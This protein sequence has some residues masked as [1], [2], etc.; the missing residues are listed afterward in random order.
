MADLQVD[1]ERQHG[2]LLEDLV[3]NNDYTLQGTSIKAQAYLD[4]LSRRQKAK[5]IAV[6]TDDGRVKSKLRELG[7]P[8]TLFG[9]D[10]ADRR[11][12][13]RHVL[14]RLQEADNEDVEMMSDNG[15]NSE[16][17]ADEDEEFY[18]PGD[19]DLLAS[20]RYIA[21]YSL[22]RANLLRA[23]L[24][25]ESKCPLTKLSRQSKLLSEYLKRFLLL[26]TQFTSTRAVSAVRISPNSQIIASGSW[27]GSIKL[28]SVPSMK[29]FNAIT[30]KGH[31]DKIGGLAWHPLATMSQSPESL[32]LVSGGGDSTIKLWS[33]TQQEPL[34]TLSGH[35][36][37]VCRIAFH[38][39]GRYLGSASFD[40]TWRFWDIETQK[41][42]LM[43]EGHSREVYCIAMQST[44]ALAASAGLDGIGRI[45][46]LRS[47]RTIMVLDGHSREIYGVDFAP[48]GY[49]VATGS[50]D[51]TIKI[52][53]IRKVRVSATIPAHQSLVSDLRFYSGSGQIPGA[54]SDPNLPS[55]DGSYLLSSS[56]DGSIKM[57]K[58]DSW[59]LLKTLKG[60]NGKVMAADV[61]SNN[62]FVASSGWDRSVKLW[63]DE[64]MQF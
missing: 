34:A 9:E 20:R 55:L 12:R 21:E 30:L 53:D 54:T 47:G 62:T 41:E 10:K 26:G 39:S 52:W 46:D 13:L 11:A 27:T 22:H 44:G 23:R 29:D 57:W 25:E 59:V 14:L 32:N 19:N 7:E 45:W 43:Q 33:L 58:S 31:S 4:E 28:L 64:L 38:P 60:H 61:A 5:S 1:G 17:I 8:I 35:E 42:L 50:G 36:A 49:Q 15:S 16:A 6:P 40:L 3:V 63:A 56:Y 18:T 24:V 2:V 51:S 37:R 48:N